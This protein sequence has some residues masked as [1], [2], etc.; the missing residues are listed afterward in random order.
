MDTEV[1]TRTAVEMTM[2]DMAAKRIASRT[3]AIKLFTM[4]MPQASAANT[5]QPSPASCF[6]SCG[7]ITPRA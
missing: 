2:A 1:E 3:I 6:Q 5:S 7:D 4:N